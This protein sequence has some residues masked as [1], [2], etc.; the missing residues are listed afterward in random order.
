LLRAA[1]IA[2]R[3]DIAIMSTKGMSVTAAR[4]L[5]DQLSP[6]VE[7]ILVLHDFDVSGFTILGTLASDSRRFRFSNKSIAM[8]DIGL[9][10]ADVEAL[11]LQSEPVSVLGKLRSRARTLEQYG[12]TPEEIAFLRAQRVE[13]NAMTSRQFVDHLEAKL[14]EHGVTKVLPEE[15]VIEGHARYLLEVMITN[16]ELE[17]ILPEVHKRA[18]AQTLPANLRKLVAK[19]FEKTPAWAWDRVVVDLVKRL[20]P[21]KPRGKKAS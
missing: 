19:Q 1:K 16:Q 4:Q 17:K 3:F 9:R 12:A 7:Q 20:P 14:A 15:K 21:P 5:L 10:L 18:A 13:L 6:R 11:D 2:E 8:I